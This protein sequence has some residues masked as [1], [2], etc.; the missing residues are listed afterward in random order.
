MGL[1]PDQLGDSIGDPIMSNLSQAIIIWNA[2]YPI[3]LDLA[4]ALMA[5]GYDVKELEERHRA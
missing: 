2:G 3:P 5:E 4:A 1:R